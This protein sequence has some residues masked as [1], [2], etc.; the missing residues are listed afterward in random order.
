LE[1][2]DPVFPRLFDGLV[3]KR[4]GGEAEVDF[5]VNVERLNLLVSGFLEFAEF[6]A[7]EQQPMTMTDWITALD[8]QIIALRVEC[9]GIFLIKFM[10][11]P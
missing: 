10:Q 8:N 7:L 2:S 3:L 11:A 9:I 4:E 1:Q 6:Q 5:E